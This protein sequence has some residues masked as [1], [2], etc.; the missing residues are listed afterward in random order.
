MR[1]III[2]IIF[3]S[4]SFL[5]GQCP[6]TDFLLQPSACLDESIEITNLTNADS[7]IWDFCSNDLEVIP[8]IG[9]EE[10]LETF[11]S[12]P[13]GLEIIYEN[14]NWM[15]F[16]MN[17]GG[18]KL[19]RFDYGN[20]LNNKPN[21]IDLGNPS[22]LLTQPEHISFLKHSETWYAVVTQNIN[23]PNNQIILLEFGASLQNI[24]TASILSNFGLS[25]KIRAVKAVVDDGNIIL[26]V[27]NS[28][29]NISIINYRDSFENNILLE[30]IIT[31]TD[32]LGANLI[33]SLDAIKV[34]DNWYVFAGSFVSNAISKIKFGA[35][36][37]SFPLEDN[38]ETFPEIDTP[39]DIDIIMQGESIFLAAGSFDLPT[40]ILSYNNIS[41]S[42]SPVIV[43]NSLNSLPKLSALD[44]VYD[45]GGIYLF[46]IHTSDE[47]LYKIKYLNN[48]NS[49]YESNSTNAPPNINYNSSGNHILSL[50]A[51][52]EDGSSNGKSKTITISPTLAPQPASQITGNCLSSPIS[53][54]GQQIEGDITS[55]NWDF[56]DG[57]G[58]SNSQTD[59]YS[60][61][62]TG[63]YQVRLSVTDANGCN[64]LLIDTVQVYNEPVPDFSFSGGTSLC[65]N[66]LV[67][68]S[69]TSTGETGDIV[70]WNWD[71]NGEGSSS[72]KEPTFTFSTAGIK[73]ITLTSSL[74]GCANVVQKT[75][76]IID[77]PTTTFSFS[78]TCNGQTNVFTDET[79]GSNLTSWNWDFGDGNTS[80]EE[81][82]SHI[83][84][85]PGEYDVTLT[86]TNNTGC[87]T[88]D[89][90]KVFNHNIP[91]VSFSNELP[92]STSSTKFFDQS[93][94]E[95]T[96]IVAWAWDF[97]DGA[98]STEQHPEHLFMQTG[99][100]TVKLKAYSQFGCVDSTQVELTVSQGPQVDFDWDKSCEGEATTFNDLTNSFGNN[101]TN[102]AWIINGELLTNQN[103]SYTFTNSGTYAVQL[104]VT[105]DNLCTQTVS[106]DIIIETLPTVQFGFD[107]SCGGNN[108]KFYD[109][110]NQTDDTIIAREWRVNGSVFSTDSL[111]VVQLE[112]GTYAIT[113]SI[114]TQ[115]GCEE[116]AVSDITLIGSPVAEFDVN[117]I[118]GAAP[119]FVNFT[120]NSSGG[121]SYVWSFGDADGTT[122]E[123]KNPG[124][125]Y[126]DTGTYTVS[127]KTYSDS[128][129]FAEATQQIEVV[130]SE[131][132]A[133]I[134]AI[135]PVMQADKTNFLLTIENNGTALLDSN[136][137]LIFR[138]D[139]GTEVIET[140]DGLIYAGKTN[141]YQS[142]FALPPS[143]SPT[144]VCVEFMANTQLD[145]ACIS[146]DESIIIS[147]P[148]PNP[149]RGKMAIDVIL[150]KDSEI[151]INVLNR[152]GQP[153][154]FK[155]VDGVTGLNE[156]I[157]D[158]QGLPQ[159]IYIVEV[160]TGEKTEI[161]KTSIIR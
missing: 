70:N 45:N 33:F 59:S 102:W 73:N 1:T 24:P 35:N 159:G 48:C 81:N 13:W 26:V 143:A 57:I 141:N 56:G 88:S 62:S 131:T 103:P 5:R 142:K 118:F 138:A 12:Q 19:L 137:S 38:T 104:S 31:T 156:L 91:V 75:L 66:N 149:S 112:P 100:Y 54:D 80:S 150:E 161:F 110:T 129:C 140:F 14:S 111:A 146:L 63:E 6:T 74:P 82:P 4:P 97:G 64:N 83:Y 145:K 34:C 69:N 107:E 36:L 154:I 7:V 90:Q 87:F 86:V 93:L 15:G 96:N 51:I 32:I 106:Q 29:K 79:T 18:G 151:K 25:N 22:G 41:S 67:T 76:E 28:G 130:P 126:S 77:A 40:S 148:Y 8:Q 30:H 144:S 78:N 21:I 60:Y 105:I 132:K 65:K 52:N 134:I 117:T 43:A 20:S 94:V 49:N 39:Y 123:E 50:N 119:L 58:T 153:V 115:A 61:A 17:R 2:L 55:W 72:E 99:G 101:I 122:S 147:D 124:F 109:L 42:D 116:T 127:L 68:F 128:E 23:S 89:T 113:L 125:T 133:T 46:G 121:S 10:D 84:S 136:M 53:F 16:L 37:F 71:F 158:G 11:A 152:S 120:N 95:N 108:T 157:I 98:T 155:S 47:L 160:T 27:A 92:C 85:L 114:I 139:Y 44:L 9:I 3:F 135:T